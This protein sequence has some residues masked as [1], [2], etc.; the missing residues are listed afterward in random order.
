MLILVNKLKRTRNVLD[1]ERPGI[2]HT[3]G[4]YVKSINQAIER[5]SGVSTPRLSNELNIP[6]ITV[7]RVSRFKLN[8][9]TYDLQ[10]QH[11][12]EHVARQAM[13]HDLVEAVANENLMNN[14]L[15]SDEATFHI[16]G[17][18]NRHNY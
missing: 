6:R 1:Q 14:I 12:W 16:Y 11:H 13:C 4:N 9:R 7:S 2:P 5:N 10:L 8:K 3:S 18:V 17:C 15:F